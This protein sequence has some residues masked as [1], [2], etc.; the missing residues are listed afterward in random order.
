MNAKANG[1]QRIKIGNV[2]QSRI[3]SQSFS[4]IQMILNNQFLAEYCIKYHYTHSMEAR[5]HESWQAYMWH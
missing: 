5:G 1:A 2:Y 4:V 3:I